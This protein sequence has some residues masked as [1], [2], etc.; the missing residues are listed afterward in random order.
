MITQALG[1]VGA[2]VASKDGEMWGMSQFRRRLRF[3]TYRRVLAIRLP[4]V[5]FAGIALSLVFVS[6]PYVQSAFTSFLSGSKSSLYAGMSAAGI[7]SFPSVLDYIRQAFWPPYLISGIVVAAV[8]AWLNKKAQFLIGVS[9]SVATCL[10]AIDIFNSAAGYGLVVSIVCNVLGGVILA[11]LSFLIVSK[12]SIVHRVSEGNRYLERVIWTIYPGACLV[13]L[14]ALLYFVLS[15]LIRIPTEPVSVRLTPPISGTISA[16]DPL[17]CDSYTGTTVSLEKCYAKHIASKHDEDFGVLHK[18]LPADAR[19]STWIG[20]G[21]KLSFEWQKNNGNA[22]STTFFM[23]EGCTDERQLGKLLKTSSAH[24]HAEPALRY[25]KVDDGLSQFRLLGPGSVKRIETGDSH[26]AVSEFWI[27][28]NASDTSKIDYKTFVYDGFFKVTDDFDDF[29]YAIGLLLFGGDN[30]APKPRRLRIGSIKD[31]KPQ[32]INIRV[33]QKS[34][35]PNAAVKCRLLPV[36]KVNDG[37]L[38]I[39][40]EPI[41][42]LVISVKHGK[43]VSYADIE[44]PDILIA[45]GVNGWISSDGFDKSRIDLG[46]QTGSTGMI[47]VFGGIDDVRVSGKDVATGP[48]STLQITGSLFVVSDGPSLMVTGDADYMTLNN[49]RLTH[50]RW[51]SLDTALRVPI[52][53][54]VPTVLFFLVRLLGEELRKARRHLWYLPS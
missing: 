43:H 37:Y 38:A 48:T 16:V 5:V 20:L 26:T 14:A 6:G 53:F 41:A 10:T 32:Y 51:E 13:T 3:R 21:K 42:N 34:A 35:D 46:M 39:A 4:L 8:I 11:L 25:I 2:S 29:S 36:K 27:T 24:L 44:K 50:T 28:P 18:F 23:A 22:I 54:G 19:K 45:S 9:A 1:R 17:R 15:F 40:S 30:G 12:I 7:G 47:S 31:S 33:N 52:V 49:Q